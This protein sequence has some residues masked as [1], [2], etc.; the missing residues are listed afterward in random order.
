MSSFGNTILWDHFVNAPVH[1]E[2]ELQCSVV[3]HWLGAFTKWSLILVAAQ[4]NET[5][6]LTST[7]IYKILTCPGL[8]YA[9]SPLWLVYESSAGVGR[10]LQCC[11]WS[12]TAV[13]RGCSPS[14]VQLLPMRASGHPCRT[15]TAPECCHLKKANIEC[16]NHSLYSGTFQAD[17]ATK[18]SLAPSV[19]SKNTLTLDRRR[20]HVRR[21][22]MPIIMLPDRS[23]LLALPFFNFDYLGDVRIEKPW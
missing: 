21:S 3:S 2:T 10:N 6:M 14:F 20:P 8:G 7:Y 23:F 16:L 9:C 5:I 4:S 19:N 11:L 17:I 18:L 13:H 22:L 12:Q 15:P 1:W